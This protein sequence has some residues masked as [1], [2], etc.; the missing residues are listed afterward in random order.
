MSND[1]DKDLLIEGHDYD[2]IMELDHPLPD[3]W[4][5]TFFITIIFSFFYWIHFEFG[6]GQTIEQE[7]KADMAK[8]EQRHNQSH[9]HKTP[10]SN[11]DL[12]ALAADPSALEGG[13]AVYAAKCAVCHANELQGSI[14]PN[15]TDD[16]WLHGKGTPQEIAGLIRLGVLDKGMP[17][18]EGQLKDAEIRKVAVYIF[19]QYGTNPPNP[20]APQ[21]DKIVRE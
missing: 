20:K 7:L 19:K 12:L 18:W 1:K 21:G 4:M 3:W 16:Y 9:K 5:I 2:G 8:L 6:G 15:L 14:G 11:S 10:E 17:A 13:K